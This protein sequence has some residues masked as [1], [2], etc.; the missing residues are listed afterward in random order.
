MKKKT[1]LKLKVDDLL[2]AR[3]TLKKNGNFINFLQNYRT[4][5]RKI[6]NNPMGDFYKE[7]FKNHKN[8]QYYRLNKSLTFNI[9]KKNEFFLN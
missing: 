9:M 4:K 7:F 2:I 5:K 8:P 6:I 3:R 1:S